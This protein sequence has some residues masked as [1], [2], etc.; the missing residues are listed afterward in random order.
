MWTRSLTLPVSRTVLRSTGDSAGAPRLFRVD[1]DNSLCGSEDATPGS[2]ACVRV[3]ALLGRVGRAGLPG[4]FWCASPFPLAALSFRFAGPPPGWGCPCFGPLFALTSSL[5]LLF[6]CFFCFFFFGL[7]VLFCLAPPLSLAF[8]GLR[9]RVPWALALCVVCFAGLALLGS[10]CALAFFVLPCRGPLSGGC[11]PRPPPL[12]C[13]PVVSGFLWFAARGALGLGAVFCLFFSASRC[14]ALRALSPRVCLLL[15]RW[16]PPGGCRPPPLPSPFVSRGFRR[17]C[18]VPWF[19]FFLPVCAAVVS[20]FLWFPAPGALGLGAARCLL[21]WPAASRLSVRSRLFCTFRLASLV[22]VAPPPLCVSRFSSLPLGAVC[23]VLCCAVCPWVCCCAALLRVVP[24]GVV[25]SCAVLLCCAGLVPLLV[26]PCPLALPVALGRCALQ[27]FVVRCSP[28]LCAVCCVCFVVAW[29]CVLLFAALLCAVCVPGCCAVCSLSSPLGAVL[30]FAMLVRLRCAV[31]LV[32]AVAGAWCCGALLCVVLFP[33]V[34]CGAVLGLVARGSLLV[35]CFGVSVPFWPRGLLPCGWRGLLCC[36]ASLCRVLWCCSVA[37]CCAVVL[38]CCVVVLLRLALPSCGLSCCAVLC[39]WLAVLFF[40]RWW[41]LRAVVL[42]PSCCAFPV[43]SALCAAVPCCAGCGALLPCVVCCGAVPS[44][45]AV[46]SCSAVVL[47]CCLC[48]LCPPVAFRVAPCCAVLCCWLSVLFFAQ[49]WRFCAV[50]PCPSL[51]ARTKNINY[52]TCHPALVAVSWP[53]CLGG[54]GVLDL[55]RRTFHLQRKGGKSVQ[56]GARAGGEGTWRIEEGVRDEYRGAACFEIFFLCFTRCSRRSFL[57][58]DGVLDDSRD[59]VMFLLALRCLRRYLF[60]YLGSKFSTSC[61]KT[62]TTRKIKPQTSNLIKKTNPWRWTDKEEAC[63]QELKRKISSTN[64]LGVSRP[65]GEM[66]LVT[67][68]CDVGGGG[69]L[70]QWQELNPN[71][72]SHCHFHTSGLNCDGTLKHDYPANEWRL[73]PLGHC[74]W[75]WNQ[76]R[77]NYSTY[78]QELLAVMLVLSFQSRLLGTN[79]VVWLCDQEPMKT[80]QKGLPPEKVKLKRWWTYLSQFRLTLHHVPGIKNEM[81]DY[82]SRNN[83]DALLGESSEALAKEAFQRMDVQLDL[84]MRT[85]G[86]LEGWSLTDYQSGYKEILQTLSTGLEPRVIDGHQWYKN[87]QPPPPRG[88]DTPQ[89]HTATH[90]P[91]APHRG[92]NTPTMPRSTDPRTPQTK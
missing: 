6:C 63:F 42:F 25:L 7:S 62:S 9:P 41:C 74:N 17:F 56:G 69:T 73:V 46:L 68:A 49:W 39:C 81:A 59:G 76:A 10:P 84:S 88:N 65:K 50:V 61:R 40:I 24:P 31:R 45:G 4:T 78:D 80:F 71:E 5:L 38:R 79:P 52:L 86:I 13:A 37:W 16:L 2:R 53:A 30:C 43:F 89:P 48:V 87:N 90:H 92:H 15:G 27:C 20:G 70:Y 75:R 82:I 12:L 60:V 64:F 28:A 44:F 47:R 22:V 8:L 33:L 29:W 26:A 58:V 3:R 23:R 57:Y 83:F 67:D 91:R 1:G 36:P 72:L 51:P 55:T 77:S 35:A 66:I 14:P 11:P 54:C 34:C 19:F 85:A 18:S 32:R 21:C